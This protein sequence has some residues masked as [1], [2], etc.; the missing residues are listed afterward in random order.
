MVEVRTNN[1]IYKNFKKVE[2]SID[3]DNLCGSFSF[4]S[5]VSKDNLY[6]LKFNDYIEIDVDGSQ[7]INGFI[8][9]LDVVYGVDNHEIRVSG[10]SIIGDILDSC[11][12][13]ESLPD[14]NGPYI[15]KIVAKHLLLLNDM[16]SLSKNI[17]N[18]TGKIMEKFTKEEILSMCVGETIYDFLETLSRKKQFLL[19]SDEY[20]NLVFSRGV[21]EASKVINTLIN[22][23]NN[24]NNNILKASLSLNNRDRF[25]YY[26]VVGS[27]NKTNTDYSYNLEN[28]V[29]QRGYDVDHD[30]RKTRSLIIISEEGSDSN[31]CEERAKW[32]KN[33]RKTRSFKYVAEVQGHSINNVP[34]KINTL[35]R[36]V[37]EFCRLNTTLLV[38]KVVFNYSVDK[39]ST[40]KLDCV[41]KDSYSIDLQEIKT[42]EVSDGF[43]SDVTLAELVSERSNKKGGYEDFDAVHK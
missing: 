41:L 1:K 42:S 13:P 6:P 3:M 7:V 8:D 31:E 16:E 34:Y 37:D 14:Y 2:I 32:E 40:T 24:N 39:G 28:I 20:G 18:M 38:K 10:R 23:I 21:G 25:R 17:K 26:T 9:T 15:L 22:R 11:I 5:S 12:Q 19:N 30:I 36:V 35:I 4:V 43:V 27:S 29:A 33:I